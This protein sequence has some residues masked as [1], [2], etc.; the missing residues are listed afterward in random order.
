[1]NKGAKV[2]DGKPYTPFKGVS[3]RTDT[4]RGSID[5][6]RVEQV[7]CPDVYKAD[8]RDEVVKAAGQLF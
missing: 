3:R 1:M 5:T 8:I 6:G 7:A 2:T 4:E